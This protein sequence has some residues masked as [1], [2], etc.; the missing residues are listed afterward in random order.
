MMENNWENFLKNLGEWRGSF[1]SIS[2]EGKLLDSTSSILNLEGFENNQLVKLRLRRFG[3][4]G[5]DEPPV[6]DYAQEYRFIG[7]QNVFFDTGAFSKR[8]MDLAIQF[9]PRSQESLASNYDVLLIIVG[10]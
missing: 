9:T 2:V 6:S 4:G 8:K 5:Y 1:T 10:F 3:P 7:G